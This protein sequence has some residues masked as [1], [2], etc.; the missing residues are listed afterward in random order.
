VRRA[1]KPFRIRE[2]WK[3]LFHASRLIHDKNIEIERALE[4]VFCHACKI[5]CN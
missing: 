3:K 5:K 4:K 2:P 1:G